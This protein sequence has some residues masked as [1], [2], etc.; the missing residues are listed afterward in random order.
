MTVPRTAARILIVEDE[1]EIRELVTFTLEVEGYT[2][3][4][5]ANGMEAFE[6]I[7]N[8]APDLV[9]LD[10][11]MPAISGL[12]V[13]QNIRQH[14]TTP[15]LILSAMGSEENRVRGL[16]LGADD[17]MTKPFSPRELAARV[18]ALLRRSQGAAAAQQTITY[19]G[20]TIDLASREVWARGDLVETTAKEFDLLAFL[21][22][23]PGRVY[24]RHQLLREVWHSSSEWQ[25]E[26]TVTE[27]IRRLRLKIE[28]DS[29][30]PRWLQTVRGV[31]YRFERRQ[32]PR[33]PSAPAVA[34]VA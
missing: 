4:P 19:D 34:A 9:I 3:L 15:V 2:V 24:T 27:H 7:E 16:Q 13:L 14:S 5:A 32:Q 25:Q 6:R 11:M 28:E 8:D 17:Y 18:Q 26:G 29:E 1:G 12:E 21:A 30:R 10:L 23:N 31:G 20:L 22:G 33:M